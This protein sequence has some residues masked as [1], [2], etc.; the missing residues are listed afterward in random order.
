MGIEELKLKVE[1]L[2][3]TI[4]I[5]TPEKRL[6]LQPQFSRLL[7]KLKEQGQQVPMRMR[8]LD[9]VLVDEVIEA[10]FDNMPV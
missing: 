2:E 5:A 9:S 7:T 8:Q 3:Q 10:R 1:H 4:A 6:A